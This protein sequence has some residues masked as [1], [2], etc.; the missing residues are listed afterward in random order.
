MKSQAPRGKFC[1]KQLPDKWLTANTILPKI[2]SCLST[3]RDV[4]RHCPRRLPPRRPATLP[5]GPAVAPLLTIAEGERCAVKHSRWRRNFCPRLCGQRY[6]PPNALLCARAQTGPGEAGHITGMAFWHHSRNLPDFIPTC[7]QQGTPLF[8][9]AECEGNLIHHPQQQLAQYIPSFEC[10]AYKKLR[11]H[12]VDGRY[13][14]AP[15]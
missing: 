2:L 5:A 3:T 14:F 4:L 9:L 11:T 13:P 12:T 1:K 8:V 7:P 15:L 6:S 10:L